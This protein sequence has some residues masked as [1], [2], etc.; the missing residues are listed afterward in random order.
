MANHLLPQLTS[1][2]TDVIAD[3]HNKINDVA[4]GLDPATVSATNLQEN[5]I[6]W[7]SASNNWQKWN[8]TAWVSL[9]SSYAISIT[10]NAATATKLATARTIGG[11]SFDG[12]ANINLP[13]VNA[14]G[15]Q[16]TSGNAA[17]ATKL[18]TARTI[19]GVSF[20]G[21]ASINLPGVNSAGN[22]NTSG[23]A[24]TA[25]R[26]LTARTIGGVSFD[27]TA[28]INLPGVNT[29]GN[30]DTSGNAATATNAVN[31]TNA[32]N[33]VS[34]VNATN[35]TNATKLATSSWVVEQSGNDIVFKFNGTT[36]LR[37]GSDGTITASNNITAYGTP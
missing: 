5:S 18:A 32:T 24:D 2:Y 26:L 35:A 16:S 20:D 8:G 3:F 25:T 27:G 33:A 4:K 23:N 1:N 6:S 29:A 14:I 10:G 13:G 31:A 30:Q 9:T 37:L 12:T 19:G 17:T 11:V 21:S 7:S 28:N 15:T 34:A 36:M 22:Q